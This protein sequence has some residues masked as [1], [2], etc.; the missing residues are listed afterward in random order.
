[1]IPPSLIGFKLQ[2]RRAVYVDWKCIPM[3]GEEAAEWK[4]R[5][6]AALGT[7]D[8][9]LR[10][11]DLRK[12]SGEVYLHRD[13]RQLAELAHREHLDYLVASRNAKSKPDMGL[14]PAFVSGGWRVYRVLP[15]RP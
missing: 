10:G 11:Y 13:L 1:L 4:R 9:P 5:M 6:L 3:K 12:G 2:A 8:F 14:E 15:F 7:E